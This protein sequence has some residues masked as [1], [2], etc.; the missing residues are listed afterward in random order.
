MTCTV[1]VVVVLLLLFLFCFLW[2]GAG[3]AGGGLEHTK[4]QT[5]ID[6][7]RYAVTET[8]QNEER[9]Q[10]LFKDFLWLAEC[11]LLRQ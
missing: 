10:R 6:M 9:I 3:E 2:G 7:I 4:G 11:N 5:I 8:G 1:F